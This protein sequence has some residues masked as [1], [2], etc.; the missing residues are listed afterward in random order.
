MVENSVG[1]LINREVI[2]TNIKHKIDSCKF[3]NCR[4]TENNKTECAF[5]TIGGLNEK[6][7]IINTS[8]INIIS[9]ISCLDSLSLNKLDKNNIN[10]AN[11][12]TIV[13]PI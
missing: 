6:V 4:R 13:I 5:S 7:N 10:V 3:Q 11:I 8:N 1:A 2:N 12:Y 9:I